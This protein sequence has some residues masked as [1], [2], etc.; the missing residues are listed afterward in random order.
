MELS[1][2]RLRA[3]ARR[4]DALA[5]ELAGAASL[6]RGAPTAGVADAPGEAVALLDA[7]V[8]AVSRLHR[9]TAVAGLRLTAALV[10]AADAHAATAL[11]RRDD[12]AGW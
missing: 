3:A 1:P 5:D 10:S 6:L 12:G 2:D 4:W 7:A 8:D 11:G 9:A